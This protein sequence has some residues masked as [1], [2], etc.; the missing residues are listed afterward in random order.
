MKIDL[1]NLIESDGLSSVAGRLGCSSPA[2]IKAI[3][4]KRNITVTVRKDG[5]CYGEEVKSF[6]GRQACKGSTA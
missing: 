5:T 6:P 2:L 4:A 1:E 3:N